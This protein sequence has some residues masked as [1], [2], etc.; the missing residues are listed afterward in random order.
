MV[1]HVSLHTTLQGVS[2]DGRTSQIDL[3]L[4][5]GIQVKDVLARLEILAA[6][7]SLILVVNQRVVEAGQLLVNGDRLDIVPAISGGS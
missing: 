3:D 1:I 4:P 5:E 2:A 6:P 7:D